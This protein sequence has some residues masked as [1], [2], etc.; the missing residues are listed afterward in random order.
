MR[1]S[2]LSWNKPVATW[3]L[4]IDGCGGF[5]VISSSSLFA[6]IGR[7]LAGSSGETAVPRIEVLAD[8]PEV[9]GELSFGDAGYQW[10]PE[11]SPRHSE[12][13]SLPPANT[14]G[15]SGRLEIGSVRLEICVPST[16]SRTG[17]MTVATPHRF[18]DHVDAVILMDRAISIGPTA[19]HPIRHPGIHDWYVL[20]PPTHATDDPQAEKPDSWR[21]RRPAD[22]TSVQLVPGRRSVVEELSLMIEP[23]RR[24]PHFQNH[25]V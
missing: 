11:E 24:A 23:C 8:L 5:Q 13:I 15:W 6:R 22:G 7:P 25:R 9:A 21:L 10:R 18:A 12:L 17:R 19:Q 2:R 4:W 14:G 3:N 16:A 20:H 1:W